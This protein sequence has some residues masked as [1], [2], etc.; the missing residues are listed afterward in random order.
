MGRNLTT[1]SLGWY[2]RTAE[3]IFPAIAC[4]NGENLGS[5]LPLGMAKMYTRI[6][7]QV[8]ATGMLHGSTIE[9]DTP[10]PPL[11]GRRVRVLLESAEPTDA[12]LS[13]DDQTRLW[14]EWE[15]Q[16]PQGAIDGDEEVEFP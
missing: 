3:A 16:G 15:T 9:L 10:V 11:E 5:K 1:R 8:A 13:A 12:N 4:G 7:P 2:C 14:H 6:M